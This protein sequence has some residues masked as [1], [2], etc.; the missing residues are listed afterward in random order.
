[1]V[2]LVGCELR[3]APRTGR[4]E[5]KLQAIL[6]ERIFDNPTLR[7]KLTIVY[8][9]GGKVATSVALASSANPSVVGASVTFT[10]TVHGSAPT[11]S[12]NFKDGGTSMTGCVAVALT[13]VG[14][15]RTAQCTTSSLTVATHSITALYGGDVGNNG[16]TSAPLSQIV[17]PAS[18]T[19]PTFVGGV[20]RK[21]HG[22]AGVFDLTLSQVSTNPTTEPR[23][24][25]AQTVVYRFNKPIVGGA[26]V[27]NEGT[28]SIGTVTF[29]GNEMTVNLTGVNNQQYVTVAVSNVVAAD[30]GTGGSGT[31]RIGYL[32]GDVNQNRV[33][34]V[35]DVGL[36][37]AVLAQPVTAAN[38]LKDINASGTLTLAD[39]AIANANGAKALPEP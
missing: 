39:K 33:V 12:V 30:G 24:G 38:Y 8:A 6:F 16:S 25:P 26:A 36:M 17:N 11:G 15:S 3:L 7:P 5:R 35:A 13:G 18:P 21:T 1:M 4:Y 32:A 28:A 37:N 29:A 23:L 14:D 10:A 9:G 20:S 19:P 31:V 2:E 34:T 22:S 27:V